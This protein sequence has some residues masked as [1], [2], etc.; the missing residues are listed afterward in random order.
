MSEIQLTLPEMNLPYLL[1]QPIYLVSARI[2]WWR[3]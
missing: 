1:D 2:T 3:F